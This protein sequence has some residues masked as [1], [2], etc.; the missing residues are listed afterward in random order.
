VTIR[1][2]GL[3]ELDR[4]LSEMKTATA[5]GVVR[6]TMV[7][8]LQ[9]M[10]DEASRLAP[11]D[12]RTTSQDLHRS[13]KV[14]DALKA[15]RSMFVKGFGFGD[16]QVTVWMGPTREGYPQAIMQEFG[17]VKQ[18]AQPYMRPAWDAGKVQ[19]LDDFAKGMAVEITKTAERA[20]RKAAK[21]AA[22]G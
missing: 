5:K 18:P 13:I 9:P 14:G 12:P 21:I 6:R 2:D 8:A 17:T 22:R 1:V 7:K 10:A 16:G 4:A 19:L 3:K 15:G 20:A 11:D